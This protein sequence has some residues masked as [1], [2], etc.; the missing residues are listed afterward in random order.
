MTTKTPK[1]PK[2]MQKRLV[3]TTGKAAYISKNDWENASNRWKSLK[4]N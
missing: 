3:E 4:N 2:M 1:Q